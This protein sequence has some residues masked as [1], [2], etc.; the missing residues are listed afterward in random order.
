METGKKIW[1]RARRYGWGWGLPC[2]WQGWVVLVAF[3]AAIIGPQFLL[4]PGHKGI[5]LGITAVAFVLLI[6]ICW[7]KGERL[8][9]RWGGN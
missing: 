2:A 7:I 3:F 6:A 9:W 4:L 8:R 1:F 5:Y